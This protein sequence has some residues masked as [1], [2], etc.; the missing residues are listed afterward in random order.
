MDPHLRHTPI[1]L[2]Q[3]PVWRLSQQSQIGT[4]SMF[5]TSSTIEANY[6]N[7][8]LRSQIPINST[9]TPFIFL[10]LLNHKLLT[11]KSKLGLIYPLQILKHSLGHN[12]VPSFLVIAIKFK[13]SCRLTNFQ[14]GLIAA[15][16][17][18]GSSHSAMSTAA[19][20][21]MTTSTHYTNLQFQNFY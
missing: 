21:I 14:I 9:R 12:S 4:R 20:H 8:L 19:S 2:Q 7:P 18:L 16:R 17:G 10:R 1:F 3:S 5:T 13:H 15:R 11:H 6:S